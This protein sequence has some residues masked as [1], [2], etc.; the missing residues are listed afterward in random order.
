MT[1]IEKN[2]QLAKAK[3]SSLQKRASNIVSR[4]LSDLALLDDEKRKISDDDRLFQAKEW[5]EKGNKHYDNKEYDEAIEAFTSAIVVD[6][7]YVDAYYS[8]G[9]AY[10]KN[11]QHDR[12]ID[13]YNKAIALNPNYVGAYYRCGDIYFYYMEGQYDRAIENFNKVIQLDPNDVQAYYKRGLVY[14]K[15]R[16]KSKAIADFQKACDLGLEVG[17]ENLQNILQG[18]ENTTSRG[19]VR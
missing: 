19:M 13:D 7:N 5:F 1:D 17:C 11:G 9:I 14:Y 16:N 6:P 15:L 18:K 4:G 2:N 12:A 3:K 8:R 10:Y